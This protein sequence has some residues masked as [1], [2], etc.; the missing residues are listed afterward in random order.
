ME[1][2]LDGHYSTVVE[3]IDKCKIELDKKQM[4]IEHRIDRTQP[5][6]KDSEVYAIRI[7]V[8]D[9]AT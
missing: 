7:G 6:T 8:L 5:A 1:T 3:G 4:D 2:F 9:E